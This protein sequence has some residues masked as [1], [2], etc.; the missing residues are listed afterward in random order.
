ML[1]I[2]LLVT[3]H[4][5]IQEIYHSNHINPM[6]EESLWRSMDTESSVTWGINGPISGGVIEEV[7]HLSSLIQCTTYHSYLN[8]H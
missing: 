8:V 6:K 5:L 2:N 7:G 4:H 1:L 3:G